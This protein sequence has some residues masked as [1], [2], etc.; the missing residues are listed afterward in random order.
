MRQG[1][2]KA[3]VAITSIAAVAA[4]TL[5]RLHARTDHGS[6]RHGGTGVRSRMRSAKKR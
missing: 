4:L 5:S 2:R 6:G 3:A 1:A